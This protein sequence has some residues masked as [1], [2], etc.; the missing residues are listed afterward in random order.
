MQLNITMAKHF[1]IVYLNFSDPDNQV[2]SPPIRL[3]EDIA[4][5]ADN[6]D[7]HFRSKDVDAEHAEPTKHRFS[8]AAL[9]MT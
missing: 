1:S 4:L 8:I 6:V 2:F 9:E 5:I 3:L 7:L